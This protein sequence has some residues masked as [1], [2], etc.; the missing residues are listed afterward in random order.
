MVGWATSYL[1]YSSIPACEEILLPVAITE[2]G[3]HQF[4]VIEQQELSDP[5]NLRLV[6]RFIN[7]VNRFFNLSKIDNVSNELVLDLELI[8]H[9]TGLTQLLTI[10]H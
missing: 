1:V 2:S 6:R 9:Q 5:A 7:K 10:C 8:V 4:V 3:H